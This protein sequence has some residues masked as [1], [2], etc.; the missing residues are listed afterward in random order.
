MARELVRNVE[1]LPGCGPA[2]LLAQNDSCVWTVLAA[3]GLLPEMKFQLFVL[4]VVRVPV[5]AAG[6]QVWLEV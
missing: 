5:L 1:C 6:L 3:T 2:S 4:L